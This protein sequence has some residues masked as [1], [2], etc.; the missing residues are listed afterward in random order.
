[1]RDF[2]TIK[3]MLL[4]AG[5][6]FTVEEGHHRETEMHSGM[7]NEQQVTT[8]EVERGYVGFFTRFEFNNDGSL[9]DLGAWE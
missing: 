7:R 1:M 6:K 4:K 8:I 9:K 2:E 3:A 5:I